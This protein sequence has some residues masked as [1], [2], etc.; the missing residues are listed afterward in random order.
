MTNR[1]RE[2]RQRRGMKQ[3]EFLQRVGR[4]PHAVARIDSNPTASVPLD[5]ALPIARVLN[6]G[7]EELVQQ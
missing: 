4:R 3:N 6:V 1:V 5:L 2:L 7:I